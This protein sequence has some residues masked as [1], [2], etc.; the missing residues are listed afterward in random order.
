MC[1]SASGSVPFPLSEYT[2]R[3]PVEGMSSSSWPL[4]LPA[5]E[6]GEEGEGMGE[7]KGGGGCVAACNW[8]WEG[9]TR[10][11]TAWWDG[12][13]QEEAMR[14]PYVYVQEPGCGLPPPP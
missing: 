13:R 11:V 6:G 14:K 4:W 8:G 9:G 10:R 5:G 2:L 7:G 12:R 1:P 3:S